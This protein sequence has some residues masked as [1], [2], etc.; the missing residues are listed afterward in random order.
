MSLINDML[1]D[2]E[3]RRN[4]EVQQKPVSTPTAVAK[5]NRRRLLLLAGA[6]LFTILTVLLVAG[7]VY[8]PTRQMTEPI[9]AVESSA[10]T[11][12]TPAP[13]PSRPPSAVA[14]QSGHTTAATMESQPLLLAVTITEQEHQLLLE[15]EFNQLPDTS[16]I[17]PVPNEG[18]VSILL[19]N[20]HIKQGLSLPQPRLEKIDGISLLPTPSGLELIIATNSQEQI[21]TTQRL[22]PR[23]GKLHIGLSFASD[24]A[25]AAGAEKGASEDSPQPVDA[26]P[27]PQVVT[28]PEQRSASP[29]ALVRSSPRPQTDEQLYQRGLQQLQRRDLLGAQQSFDAVLQINPQRLAARL[30]LVGVLQ[31]LGDERRFLKVIEEGLQLHPGQSDLRKLYAH[32]LLFSQRHREGLDLLE[33]APF[34]TVKDEP[35]YHALRAAIYQELGEYAEAAEV[36]ARLLE[37]R[38]RESLWWMGLAIALEQQGL[39]GGARDAYRTALD[40]SGLRPDLESFVRERLQSL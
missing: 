16:E 35:E 33:K 13:D 26:V 1:R 39:T 37:Q 3:Q 10:E 8:S 12:N 5:T 15:L 25:R 27:E 2:L 23:T 30:E 24:V 32:H 28:Q 14:A 29:S 18:R 38:P 20:T 21:T 31:R 36:Y 11:V 19:Q 7:W 34:P 4:K 40:V 17:R 22:E 6:G 9:A